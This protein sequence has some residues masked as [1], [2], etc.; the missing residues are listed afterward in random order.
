MTID[1]YDSVIQESLQEIER[2]KFKSES[3]ETR[4]N[5]PIVKYVL[6]AM[7]EVD[8]KYTDVSI[9]T[10]ERIENQL[11][12]RLKSKGIFTRFRLQ[13]SVPL[14]IH[15]KGISDVDLLV[16]DNGVFSYDNYGPK[17][18]GY[19]PS[20]KTSLDVLKVLRKESIQSLKDAFPRVNVDTSGAKSIKLTG[21]SLARD[22]DVVP[23]NW[24][25]TYTYQL[26]DKE[27]DRGINIYDSVNEKINFNLPFKHISLI[28]SKC[29][30]NRGSLRKSIRLCKNL[31]ADL[32]AEGTRIYLSSYDLAALMYHVKEVNLYDASRNDLL[33]LYMTQQHFDMLYRNKEY[34]LSLDT[35]D[36]TRKII[37]SND[38]FT[39]LLH[40][41]CALDE[42]VSL[43]CESLNV[44]K[45][46]LR[47]LSI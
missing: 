40:L 43:V 31:K 18:S 5:A 32:I 27:E 12:E 11:Y 42:L 47:Y 28:K 8:S 10:A 22:V 37:D 33:V 34:T 25:N 15:I 16:I 4:S 2:L 7:E 14:N 1:S 20:S 9:K 6:G 44:S 38:K 23:S 24:N 35:P 3:W 13:G 46:S 45:E 26:T 30:N 36:S 39:S 21:G 17:A 29:L 41:S 19:V